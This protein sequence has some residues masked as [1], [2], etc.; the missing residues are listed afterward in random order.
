MAY[1]HAWG[2]RHARPGQRRGPITRAFQE[3]LE[4]L[5]WGFHNSRDGRCFPS[6]GLMAAGFTTARAVSQGARWSM[7]AEIDHERSG[8][9]GEM[10]D[11]PTRSVSDW[12]TIMPLAHASPR[13]SDR[14]LAWSGDRDSGTGAESSLGTHPAG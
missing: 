7:V 3:V 13:C 10:N 5:L 8:Y 1:A 9:R 11:K 2:A 6:Y 14:R 4:A 12:H